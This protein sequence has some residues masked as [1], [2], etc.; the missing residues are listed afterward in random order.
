MSL[1]QIDNIYAGY[2][3]GN[4]IEDIS[5]EI[6]QG[7]LIGILGFNGS[8]KSTLAKA[9]CNLLPHSGEVR[10]GDRTLSDKNRTETGRVI[11]YVPQ[12]SGIGIDISVLDVVLMGCNVELRLFENPTLAM[13]ERALNVL[14]TVG[15]S[16]KANSNYM[17]LSEGQKR[18]VILARALVGDGKLLVMDEPESALDYRIRYHIMDVARDWVSRGERAGLVI[19]H[20]IMLALNKCDRLILL[21]DKKNMGI[22]DLHHDTMESIQGRL[23]ALYGDISLHQVI[24]KSGRKS[25]VMVYD[26]EGS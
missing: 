13:K 22:I 5:L 24:G 21:S 23:S 16:H 7:E 8:G 11:Q 10:I 17:H 26:S 3:N 25:L 19:L 14:N 12:Q 2:G 20:D 4:V 18:L 9:I 15:L 6:N 1:I